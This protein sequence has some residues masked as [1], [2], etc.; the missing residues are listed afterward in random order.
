MEVKVNRNTDKRSQRRKN[1]QCY[2][3]GAE[4]ELSAYKRCKKCREAQCNRRRGIFKESYVRSNSSL[5]QNLPITFSDPTRESRI[6]EQEKKV[7]RLK[8]ALERANTYQ[9]FLTWNY[10]SLQPISAEESQFL[11]LHSSHSERSEF[12][13]SPSPLSEY[14]S[15]ERSASLVTQSE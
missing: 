3:C 8:R 14:Q 13:I 7:A 12:G 11:S 9:R 6:V 4:L 2:N 10:R 5:L 15:R 1:R